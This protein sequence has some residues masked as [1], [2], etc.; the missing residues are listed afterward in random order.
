MEIECG[1]CQ[2]NT[3]ITAEDIKSGLYRCGWCRHTFM[4]IPEAEQE[5]YGEDYFSGAHKNWFNNPDYPLFEFIHREILKLPGNKRLKILD[6]GCGRGDL[7]EYLK[8]KNPR[9]ELYGIDLADNE[10]PGITFFK[11]DI[12]KSDIGIRFDVIVNLSVIEH[13]DSPLLF[14][15]KLSGLSA[16]GGIIFTVTVNNDGMIFGIARLLKKIGIYS[17]YNRLY[18]KQHLQYFSVNSLAALM[19]EY[20]L[21][22]ITQKKR[23]Y[24]VRAVDYPAANFFVTGLYKTAIRII[25]SLS[26]ALDNGMLQ[27]VV[28]RNS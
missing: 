27:L 17:A 12:L 14:M 18:D 19:R 10:Y 9:L 15:K 23:N 21:G 4:N 25:F 20:G 22:I 8:K 1:I 24:P 2:K 11:G 7:L 28:C 13:I 16:P 6:A 26:T 5:M 3:G